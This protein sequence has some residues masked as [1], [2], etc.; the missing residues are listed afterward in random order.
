MIKAKIITLAR[1]F[2]YTEDRLEQFLGLD[3]ETLS[4]MP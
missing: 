3:D 1:Q 2:L 4:S